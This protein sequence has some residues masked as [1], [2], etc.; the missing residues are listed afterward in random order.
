MGPLAL[1]FSKAGFVDSAVFEKNEIIGFER[2]GGNGAQQPKAA[3]NKGNHHRITLNQLTFEHTGLLYRETETISTQR[4][5][6]RGL[7]RVYGP[8]SHFV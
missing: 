7:F 3:D 5:R 2:L 1:L 4:L 8:L 6:I